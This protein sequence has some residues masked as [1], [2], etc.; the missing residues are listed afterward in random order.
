MVKKIELVD[1]RSEQINEVLGKRPVW[2]IRW[3]TTVAF[4]FILLIALLSWG[5]KYPDVISAQINITTNIPPIRLVAQS[6]GE[7]LLLVKDGTHVIKN[8][9]LGVTR[10]A[11]N[12]ENMQHLIF[13]LDSIDTALYSLDS[14]DISYDLQL[15]E[16]QPLLI[17]FERSLNNYHFFKK[18]DPISQDKNA[19]RSEIERH[20][21]LLH[22]QRVRLK[23]LQDRVDLIQSDFQRS[24]KLY[25]DGVVS[26]KGLEEEKSKLLASQDLLQSVVLDVT[27][28]KIMLSSL[29]D[30]ISKLAIQNLEREQF[31]KQAIDQAYS[32]LQSAVNK[33]KDKYT[34]VAPFD[35][36][37]SLSKYWTNNQYVESGKEVMVI[38][39]EDQA[40]NIIGKL[41]LPIYNSGKVKPGQRV[42]IMLD[43]Y[44][45]HEYGILIGTIKS[46]SEV[47][48]EEKYAAEVELKNGLETSYNKVLPFR[49][50]LKGSAE[51]VTDDLRLFQRIIYIFR[52]TDN[53]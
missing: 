43:N 12:R 36:R 24:L 17:N 50:E 9:I 29:S 7:L 49:H 45:Y 25:E 6:S 48:R 8:E 31:L 41:I 27:N 42:N 47:P 5:V 2:M 15:G 52:A 21:E 35:G 3:G 40:Y 23:I 4:A 33:W 18:Y 11:A 22:E 30:Q 13:F 46:I 26:E 53:S 32:E 10:S 44:P 39:P 38:I 37:V 28:T 14:M 20:N 16:M 19:V 1:E 51:V 34:L